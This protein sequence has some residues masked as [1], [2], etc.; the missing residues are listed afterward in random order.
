MAGDRHNLHR[1]DAAVHVAWSAQYALEQ[2]LQELVRIARDVTGESNVCLAGGVAL[3]CSANGLVAEPVYVPP[4]PHDAG[5]AL[6]AA[7]HVAPPRRADGPLTPF[8]GP[9]AMSTPPAPCDVQGLVSVPFDSM[10]LKWPRH[11]SEAEWV[12]L[13]TAGPR[14]DRELLVTARSWRCRRPRAFGTA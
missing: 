10:P 2:G 7:W 13:F 14:R 9:A 3:N 5:V 6:G 4:V 8:L 11:S 12:L 1:D